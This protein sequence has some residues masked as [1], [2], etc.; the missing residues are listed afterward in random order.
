[1]GLLLLLLLGGDPALSPQALPPSS[2]A[3]DHAVIAFDAVRC[4]HL[5]IVAGRVIAETP[6]SLTAAQRSALWQEYGLEVEFEWVRRPD[7]ADACGFSYHELRVEAWPGLER[8]WHTWRTCWARLLGEASPPPLPS[9]ELPELLAL[10]NDDPRLHWAAPDALIFEWA[11][12]AE[13]DEWEEAKP[14]SGDPP[15]KPVVREDHAP[16]DE[17][18]AEDTRT[19]ADLHPRTLAGG[20]SAGLLTHEYKALAS[21][22]DWEEAVET[23]VRESTPDKPLAVL[24]PLPEFEYYRLAVPEGSPVE[25]APELAASMVFRNRCGVVYGTGQ[26]EALAAYHAAGSPHLARVTVCVA[27]TGVLRSHPELQD[28]LHPNM[29]DCNYTSLRLPALDELAGPGL[30]IVEREKDNAAGL[31]RLAIRGRPASHGTNCAGVVLRCTDGFA[32]GYD[33][34]GA[35]RDLRRA[36]AVRILPASLKSD[37]TIAFVGGRIKTPISS[38]IRL[39]YGLSE[40]FPTG[41]HVPQPGDRVQNTGDVR[42]VSVSA[43]VPKSYFNEAEWKV[44]ANLAGKAQGAI[45]E[46]LRR[47]DRVYVFAAGN[48]AQAYANKPGDAAFVLSA[49]AAQAFDG[50]KAWYWPQF[51]EGSNV[52][53]E[54]VSAPGE[55]IITSTIYPCPNLRYLPEAEFSRN[56]G[57]WSTPNT[58]RA[59]VQQTNTFSA[60]SSA[61]PQVAALAALLYAQDPALTYEGVIQRVKDSCGGRS[62]VAPYGVSMGLIDYRSAL[63]W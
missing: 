41:E 60:T 16:I 17:P 42:V 24:G 12:D 8:G 47:N 13:G 40:H 61:T 2:M 32:G 52:A 46:D 21:V 59:W 33:T 49:S 62:L 36:P 31:P 9:R 55:G 39:V 18:A 44:V 4:P 29:L 27:D 53:P 51:K 1:M 7:S 6:S 5:Q 34:G 57:N 43:G 22:Q 28:V 10:L 15:A 30:E 50:G 56:V 58:G 11:Q 14:E 63:G 23:V 54:C 20:Y 3:V 48:E 35:T 38:F 26:V 25:W 45:A 37:K 19:T